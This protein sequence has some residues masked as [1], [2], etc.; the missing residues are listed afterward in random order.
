MSLIAAVPGLGMAI[1]GAL[2]AL[3]GATGAQM[4]FHWF[5]AL[6]GLVLTLLPLL[7][8][9]NVWPKTGAGKP[10]AAKAAV[11]E[12]AGKSAAVAEAGSEELD[13]AESDE[14]AEA[15]DEF[16]AVSDDELEFGEADEFEEE[17]DEKK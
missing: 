9:A 12:K 17:D 4:L 5:A 7:I 6:I 2:G 3:G 8:F 15:S 10:P 16:S 14:F 1:F 11:A 13:V